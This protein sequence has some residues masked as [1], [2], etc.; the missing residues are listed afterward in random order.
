MKVFTSQIIKFF[1]SFYAIP[2]LFISGMVSCSQAEEEGPA[3]GISEPVRIGAEMSKE[4]MTRNYQASG[5]VVTGMYYL[6]Y[7]STQNTDEVATVNFDTSE[8]T[9]GIGIV[10]TPDNDELVWDL[11]G[12]GGTPIM[13]LDNVSGGATSAAVN[14]TTITF[15]DDYNPYIAAPFDS[16]YGKND[17]LWGQ[18]TAQ[19]GAKKV[20][21]PLYH[22]MSRL[23][24]II[25]ADATNQVNDE[26]NL[27]EN[28]TVTLTSIAQTPVSYNRLDGS[29]DLGESPD[30]GNFNLVNKTGEGEFIDWSRTYHP[31]PSNPNLTTYIS[32]DFVVPP[33][34][35]NEGDMRP[36]LEITTAGGK[37]FSGILPYAMEVE[38]S[39]QENP[40]PVALA[41]LKQHYLTIETV[42][43]QDPPELV[44]MPV[45]VIE[46]VDKGS[47]TLTGQQAGIYMNSDFMELIGYFSTG[48]LYQ[49]GRY[50]Y[51]DDN[52]KWVFNIWG[53][54]LLQWSDVEKKMAT[55][56]ENIT[57]FSFQ[58]NGYTI[59][60][61]NGDS[62]QN[63]S[64]EQLYNL[65]TTG[66]Y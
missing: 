60:I 9:Q 29:L 28:S 25:T 24:V 14:S 10:T 26:V 47:W 40:Y 22:N 13:V 65:V 63:I 19:R 55:M 34:L 37:T 12:G 52:G 11:V 66:S 59:T 54:L 42:I 16:D 61:V 48:N 57:G 20:T 27:N 44:F 36:R 31:D 51:I 17:L 45:K 49:L 56:P 64:A 7:P 58:G 23:R 18:Q 38:Y 53:N 6:T 50:G 35:P 62:S 33:Q 3:P 5:E 32:V 41:F 15:N 1:R 2:L 39:D 4:L 43:T 30:Y 46:W 8:A 21:F